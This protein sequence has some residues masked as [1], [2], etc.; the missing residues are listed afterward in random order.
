MQNNEIKIIIVED[1]LIISNNLKKH[2]EKKENYKVVAQEVDYERAISSIKLHKPNIVL[3]DIK[4]KGQK[5]GID[6]G[7]FLNEEFQ[8]TPFIFITSYIDD[9]TIEKAKHTCPAGYL[10]KPFNFETVKSTIEIA[11]YNFQ[12]NKQ[13]EIIEIYDGKKAIRFDINKIKYIISDKVYLE[14][15]LIDKKILIRSTL[16]NLLNSLP[17]NTFFQINRSNIINKNFVTEK[18]CSKIFIDDVEFHVSKLFVEVLKY[19]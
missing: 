19:L 13:N 5:S 9:Q 14:I 18:K 17:Q 16:Y 6:I 1:E 10:S 2:I 11:L 7:K 15:Y 3:I 12:K 4:L 8:T